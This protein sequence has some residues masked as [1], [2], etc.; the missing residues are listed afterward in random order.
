MC[1]IVGYIGHREAFPVILNGLRR[2][3][4]RGYDSAGLALCGPSGFDYCKTKGKVADLEKKCVDL[5]KTETMGMGHTRGAT[6][7][8]LMK[9]TLTHIFPILETCVSFIMVL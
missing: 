2:L 1:G 8:E 3:E 7:A 5:P 6:N 9:S 4:Y